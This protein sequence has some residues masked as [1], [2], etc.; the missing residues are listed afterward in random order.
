MKNLLT[1]ALSLA[2]AVGCSKKSDSNGPSPVAK[3]GEAPAPAAP[4]P[5]EEA[6]FGATGIAECD[7][8]LGT[9]KKFQA[10]SKVKEDDRAINDMS[11]VGLKDIT[12]LVA[13]AKNPD[14]LDVA[15]TASKTACSDENT[16]LLEALKA[17]G[18]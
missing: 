7:T 3:T 14:D 10:C 12:G 4:A 2:L 15:K 18:C 17:A 6:P 11:M 8:V 1:F 16:R 5:A 13:G 9:Y